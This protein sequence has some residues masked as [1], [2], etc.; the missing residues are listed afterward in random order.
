MPVALV[1]EVR[2]NSPNP[3]PSL[4]Q[5]HTLTHCAFGNIPHIQQHSLHLS[6]LSIVTSG[7]ELH[8]LWSETGPLSSC[9]SRPLP[10]V[11]QAGGV[12]ITLRSRPFL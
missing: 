5:T 7:N 11:H 2:H 9:T 4:P 12:C 3:L 10:R 8:W 6:L 1:M